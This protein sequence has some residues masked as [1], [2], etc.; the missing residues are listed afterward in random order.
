MAQQEIRVPVRFYK[1]GYWGKLGDTA[2]KHIMVSKYEIIDSTMLYP[3]DMHPYYYEDGIIG[4]NP[5]DPD[6]SAFNSDYGA[7]EIHKAIA[8]ILWHMVPVRNMDT[9]EVYDSLTCSDLI[10]HATEVFLSYRYSVPD[11][12]GHHWTLDVDDFLFG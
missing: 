2:F 6:L 4:F 7:R 11:R 10:M 9:D 5:D 8:W 1:R 3:I 12:N